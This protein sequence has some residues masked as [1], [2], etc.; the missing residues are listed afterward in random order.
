MIGGRAGELEVLNALVPVAMGALLGIAL[1]IRAG[2]ARTA[3]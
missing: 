3:V 2:S 1:M